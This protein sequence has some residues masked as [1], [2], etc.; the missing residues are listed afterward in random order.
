MSRAEFRSNPYADA[1]VFHDPQLSFEGFPGQYSKETG[2]SRQRVVARLAFES[3]YDNPRVGMT[4]KF[5]D[6]R[7]VRVKC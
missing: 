5:P 6:V 3:E 1:R 4:W 7:E 2:A